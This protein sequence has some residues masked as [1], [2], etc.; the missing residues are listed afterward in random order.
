MGQDWCRMRLRDGADV[1]T[2]KRLIEEQALAWSQYQDSWSDFTWSEADD[3][4]KYERKQA[5]QAY[6]HASNALQDHLHIPVFIDHTINLNAPAIMREQVRM[7]GVGYNDIFPEELRVHAFRTYLP[8]ELP[9][10]VAEW[11]NFIDGVRAGDYGAYLLD[12]HLYEQ[13][14]NAKLFWQEL[15]ENARS[16]SHRSNAWAQR[17]LA[18]S[19]PEQIFTL[20]EPITYALPAWTN[21][22][23]P[24]DYQTDSRYIE[25]QQTV[26]RLHIVRKEWNRHVSSKAKRSFDIETFEK[27]LEGTNYANDLLGWLERCVADGVGV[28]FYG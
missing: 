20:P 7:G 26:D 8:D 11:K 24:V 23:S 27:Y 3:Y 2:V 17:L 6:V 5:T 15:Q 13:S 14:H 1:E 22:K 28:Y 19:I 4:K 25:L 21:D 16:L 9:A 10:Q 18:T 12:Y